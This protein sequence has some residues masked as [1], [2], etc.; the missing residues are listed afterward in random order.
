LDRLK[1][2]VYLYRI[3]FR[4]DLRAQAT[5]SAESEVITSVDGCTHFAIVSLCGLAPLLLSFDMEMLTPLLRHPALAAQVRSSVCS[6]FAP[7]PP[8]L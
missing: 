6:Q 5:S 7:S 3:L 4:Q 1:E 8:P 2:V